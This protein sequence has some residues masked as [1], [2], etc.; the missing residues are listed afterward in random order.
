VNEGV[1]AAVEELE[2]LQPECAPA[3]EQGDSGS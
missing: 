2:A 3:L 1:Q